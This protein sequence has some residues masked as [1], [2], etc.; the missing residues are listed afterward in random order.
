MRVNLGERSELFWLRAI[1]SLAEVIAPLSVSEAERARLLVIEI[2]HLVTCFVESDHGS[3]C[4]YL[5]KTYFSLLQVN[6]DANMF[7][8][9]GV[10]VRYF[11]TCGVARW[12]R[13]IADLREFEKAKLSLSFITYLRRSRGGGKAYF[14]SRAVKIG[15]PMAP[16]G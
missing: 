11:K 13:E 4:R 5:P 15:L 2:L 14:R 6:F 10:L 16:L 12:D 8:T 7:W 9:V 1:A 3:P